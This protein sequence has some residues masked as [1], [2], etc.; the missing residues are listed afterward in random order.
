MKRDDDV[1]EE[2]HVLIPEWYGETTDNGGKDIEKLGGTIELVVFVDKG[3]ETFVNC[4]ANH[5]S[6]WN[7]LSV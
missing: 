1:L 3:E 4:L 7:E 2:N 6:S 5:L